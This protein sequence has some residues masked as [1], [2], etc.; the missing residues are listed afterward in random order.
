MVD[1]VAQ[2]YVHGDSL[3]NHVV[4]IVVPDPVHF[5]PLAS[6]TLNTTIDPSDT[7]ALAEAAKRPQVVE[8]L[9]RELAPFAQKARLL[10]YEQLKNNILIHLEPFTVESGALTATLKLKRNVV[11]QTFKEE[12]RE[13]Y[14]RVPKAVAKM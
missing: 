9:G 2:I 10:G 12:L 1:S 4:G 14:A 8:A 6:K 3:E 11:S 13:L 5:A 7:Q